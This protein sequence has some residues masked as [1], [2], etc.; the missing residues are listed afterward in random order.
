MLKWPFT[1]VI[2]APLGL[3]TKS[4]VAVGSWNFD[5]RLSD[6][7]AGRGLLLINLAST[8]SF[9]EPILIPEKY[10]NPLIAESSSHSLQ[11][12]ALSLKK[13]QNNIREISA[14]KT[15]GISIKGR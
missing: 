15:F 12:C 1:V 13:E 11:D 3:S 8:V 6:C 7:P 14:R 9:V 5:T 2:S 10:A 4:R